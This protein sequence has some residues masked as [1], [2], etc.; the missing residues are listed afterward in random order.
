M[1]VISS[2]AGEADQNLPYATI[3]GLND[4]ESALMQ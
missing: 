3:H 4:R 1:N 2:A